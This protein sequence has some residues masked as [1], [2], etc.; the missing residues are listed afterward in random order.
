MILANFVGNLFYLLNCCVPKTSGKIIFNGFPDFED[1][2]RGLLPYL[3]G[4]IIVLVKEPNL[5]RPNWLPLQV[6][7]VQKHSFMGFW[8]IL[9]SA[10]IYYTHGLFS[11]FRTISSEKQFVVNLWHGMGLKNVG[12][13]DGKK[14]MPQSHKTICTSPFFQKVQAETFGMNLEDVLICGLPRN[15]ILNKK[16]A[17]TELIRIREKY[18]KCYVWLPTYRKSGVGDIRID[19]DTSSVF[20][21]DDFDYIRLNILLVEKNEVLIIKPHPMAVLDKF[22]EELSNIKIISESWLTKNSTTLYELLSVSD[23][24]WTDYSSVFVDYLVTDKPIVFIAPDLELYKKSRGFSFDINEIQ[25]PGISITTQDEFFDLAFKPP[26]QGSI[27]MNKEI[28]NTIRRY[29]D[30]LLRN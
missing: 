1:M 28:F 8:H 22:N 12:L 25:L 23:S 16:T 29:N 3:D 9:T 24:L 2:L 26:S 18:S 5:V 4:N 15:D 30:N 11:F 10:E 7:I 6:E 21:F 17:N 14:N 27:K 19:G 13:L 20:C